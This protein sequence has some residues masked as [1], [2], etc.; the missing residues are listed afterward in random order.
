MTPATPYS[1]SV[2]TILRCALR[3]SDA[4]GRLGGEEFTAIF[5]ATDAAGAVEV[6]EPMRAAVAAAKLGGLANST[7]HPA[8]VSAL[9]HP[10]SSATRRSLTSC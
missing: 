5:P 6:A 1:S 3:D 10:N 8:L 7:H 9:L 2:A 4:L